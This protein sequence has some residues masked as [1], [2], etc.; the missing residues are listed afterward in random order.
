[1]VE[2]KSFVM[3]QHPLLAFHRKKKK[4]EHG[5]SKYKVPKYTYK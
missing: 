1:M 5:I 3:E 4:I 2:N